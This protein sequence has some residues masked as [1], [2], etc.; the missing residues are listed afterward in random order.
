[1]LLIIQVKAYGYCQENSV[2]PQGKIQVCNI[3]L[4]YWN[5]KCATLFCNTGTSFV[6]KKGSLTVRGRYIYIYIYIYI[7]MGLLWD[8]YGTSLTGEWILSVEPLLKDI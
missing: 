6:Y 5:S 7:Y 8:Q 3:V 2:S 1:M 4:Q